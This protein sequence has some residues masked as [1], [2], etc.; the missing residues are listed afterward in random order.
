MT[1]ASHTSPARKGGFRLADGLGILYP[2]VITIG[3]ILYHSEIGRLTQAHGSFMS[4]VKFA[5]LATYGECVKCRIANGYWLPSRIPLRMIVWGCFGIWISADFQLVAVGTDH[6]IETGVWWQA[7]RPLSQSIWGNILSGYAFTMM[8]S[9]YWID[10][11]VDGEFVW[12]WQLLGRPEALGW[13]RIVIPSMVIFWV[14]AHTITFSLPSEY[15]VICAAY[16]SIALG[17]ILSFAGCKAS[18]PAGSEASEAISS[19]LK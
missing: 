9:H 17:L 19:T 15:R 1:S 18:A 12:P 14:P 11:L 2:V 7:F 8:F 6:L 10:H 5:L 4:F 13:A 3:F 16:L